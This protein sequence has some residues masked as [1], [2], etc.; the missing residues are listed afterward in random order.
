M[1]IHSTPFAATPPVPLMRETPPGAPYP[2]E[3]LGPLRPAVE[4]IHDLTQAP[5][6]I[7]AQSVLGV[8]SL[9]AQ[10][11]VDAETLH[12]PAP[13]SLFLLTIAQ[14][15][16]R[17]S[18]CDRLAM[19][20]VTDFEREIADARKAE[21]ARHRDRKELWEL[22]RARILKGK[23]PEIERAADLAALGAEPEPPLHASIISAEPT[24]EG[25][26]KNMRTLRA[27]LGI[28]SDEG[29]SFIG[30]H[31][32]T[33]ENRMRTI[34]GLSG[35]WDGKPV[36][37]W[38]SGDGVSEYRGRRLS[39]NLMTQPIVAQE[40]LGDQLAQGQGF[41]ARF[42]LA[43]PA[44]AIGTRTRLSTDPRSPR[45]LD[46]YAETIG[47]LLR[48]PLPLRA[49][50]RNE[51]DV[52]LLPLSPAAREVL[53]HFALRIE[54]AQVEGG[55]LASIRPFASKAAEHAARLAAVLSVFDG[56]SEVPG[57]TMANAVRLMDYYVGEALRLTDTATVS[58][59]TLDAVRVLRWLHKKWT[60]SA[61]SAA[62]AAQFGP[63]KETEKSRHVLQTLERHGWLV[64]SEEPMVIRGKRRREVWHIV[65]E[66]D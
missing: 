44:S 2:M 11:L 28:F 47:A 66:A 62:D 23:G 21:V 5:L 45:T 19:R 29:G 46:A 34:S 14:S 12:G 59:D 25:I 54:T 22:E 37:R 42:L 40:L 15:G 43:Q 65:R 31:G 10:G 30:G 64:P 58:K 13:C 20:P 61:I 53:Q 55:E 41:L 9:A 50:T 1:T 32:M 27:S 36:T 33:S 48:R 35:L 24:F 26:T 6:G 49:D 51:L 3:A 57:D 17:K 4:A 8:A 16:E 60:E 63:F 7:C 18:A 52:P 39:V 56:S 38:R